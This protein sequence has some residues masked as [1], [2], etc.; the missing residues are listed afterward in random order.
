MLTELVQSTYNKVHYKLQAWHGLG[1]G[2]E[3]GGELYI[4]TVRSTAINLMAEGVILSRVCGSIFSKDDGG[5]LYEVPSSRL[6]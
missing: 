5:E 1:P 4:C 6:S 2:L 3:G